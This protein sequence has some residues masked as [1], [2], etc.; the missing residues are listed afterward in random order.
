MNNKS[1]QK[2]TPAQIRGLLVNKL[3]QGLQ[4]S[5]FS[6]W[7]KKI[8]LVKSSGKGSGEGGGSEKRKY[9]LVR[10]PWFQVNES[11]VVVILERLEGIW[12]SPFCLII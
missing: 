10:I 4:I 8:P 11:K 2:K 9:F 6:P 1:P 3:N 7:K 5:F 12:D